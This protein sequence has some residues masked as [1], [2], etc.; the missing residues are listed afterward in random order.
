[1][2]SGIAAGLLLAI[3]LWQECISIT[4]ITQ[5]AMLLLMGRDIPDAQLAKEEAELLFSGCS[6]S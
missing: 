4:A 5:I 6:N 3:A 2:A 1:M